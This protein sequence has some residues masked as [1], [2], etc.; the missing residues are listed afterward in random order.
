NQAHPAAIAREAIDLS[1]ARLSDSTFPG[2]DA[3]ETAFADLPAGTPV[4]FVF[5]PQHI[6]FLPEPGSAIWRDVKT[7]KNDVMN[8]VAAH[9]GW[10][11]LDFLID[12]PETRD[13]AN[14]IDGDHYRAGLAR[15]IET[16]LVGILR[17]SGPPALSEK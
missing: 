6:S 8:R 4:I 1:P 14:F 10:H 7:C 12:M 16:R 13:P 9:D 2:L 5:P 17:P 11:Y 3:F 15:M